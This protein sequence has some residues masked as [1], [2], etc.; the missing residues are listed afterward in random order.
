MAF[1]SSASLRLGASFGK[2]WQTL[3][4]YLMMWS[5]QQRGVVS[6]DLGNFNEV[7]RNFQVFKDVLSIVWDSH[8]SMR[9][10]EFGMRTAV[11]AVARKNHAFRFFRMCVRP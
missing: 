6:C 5:A 1:S 2:L 3:L 4:D 9:I 10:F 7:A 11:L 8:C